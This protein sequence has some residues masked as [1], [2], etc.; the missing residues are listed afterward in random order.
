MGII[1]IPDAQF[2][3]DGEIIDSLEEASGFTS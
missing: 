3:V 2:N 1:N